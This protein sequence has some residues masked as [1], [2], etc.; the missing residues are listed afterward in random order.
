MADKYLQY[1]STKQANVGTDP[2]MGELNNIN[3]N[4]MAYIRPHASK[5]NNHNSQCNEQTSSNQKEE[6]LDKEQYNTGAIN[7]KKGGNISGS[8][9]K[10]TMVK[11]NEIV[12]TRSVCTVKKPDRLAYTEYKLAINIQHYLCH[13]GSHKVVK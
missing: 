9:A 8:L 7:N 10:G 2:L 6:E 13:C 11:G 4:P 3:K 1:Q 12:K 5:Q